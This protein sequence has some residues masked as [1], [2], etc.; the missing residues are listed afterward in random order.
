MGNPKKNKAKNKYA[1]SLEKALRRKLNEAIARGLHDEGYE[2][3]EQQAE[4]W[5]RE[6]MDC[7]IEENWR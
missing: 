6:R 3:E 4:R 2:T 1:N 7:I 5:E